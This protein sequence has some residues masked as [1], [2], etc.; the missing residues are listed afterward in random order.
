VPLAAD[1]TVLNGEYMSKYKADISYIGTNL[2]DKRTFYESHVKPL[3]NSY[4]LRL[5]GQDWTA[6]DKYLGLIQKVGQYFKLPIL[7]NIS[8]PSLSL[9]DEGNIYASTTISINFHE[10]YQKKYGGDCNERTFKIP[11]AGGFEIVDNVACISKYFKENKEI[12]I[13]HDIKDWFDK[14]EYFI[15]HP[16][17]RINIIEAGKNKVLKYHTYHNRVEFITKLYYDFVHKL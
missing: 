14:I 17:K 9:N 6:F 7:D 4:N 3:F 8:R 10:E 15:S 1:K 16:E 12:I 2:P 5:Y 11:A 13:G